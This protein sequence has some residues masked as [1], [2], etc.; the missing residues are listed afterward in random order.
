[1]HVRAEE[2]K[3]EDVGFLLR[4]H[5]PH[6]VGGL[7][8]AIDDLDVGDHPLEGIVVGIEDQRPRGMVNAIGGRWGHLLDDRFEDLVDARASLGRGRDHL[9]VEQP[10]ELADFLR[11]TLGIGVGQVDLVDDRDDGKVM[12][13]REVDIGH[14][15]RFDPLGGVDDQQG[16]FAGGK[17]TAYFIGEINVA[18]RVDQVEF[19]FLPVARVVGHPHGPGL[20]RDALLAL[21]V[22]GVQHLV[23]QVALGHGAGALEEAIGQGGLPVVDVGDDAEVSDMGRGGVCH[24]CSVARAGGRETGV[25]RNG[26]GRRS[27]QPRPCCMVKYTPPAR[28]ELTLAAHARHDTPVL[29]P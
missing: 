24:G 18:R 19:V 22:H 5:H 4:P 25:A 20:D 17:R 14:R 27:A 9:I 26:P 3:F 21:Q 12:L 1:M 23:G 7:D 28:H 10:D 29:P 11:D 2:P 15:L 8:L 16:A 6:A 13:Q